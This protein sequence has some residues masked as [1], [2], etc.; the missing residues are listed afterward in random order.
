MSFAC[1]PLLLAALATTVLAGCQKKGEAVA[2]AA[3][4]FRL[5]EAGLLQPIRFAA[6]DIDPAINAC[7]DLGAHVNARWLAANPIPADQTRWGAFGV[8]AERSV[9]VQRQLAEQVAA[10]PAPS[11]IEKIVADFWATGM[12]EA[13]LNADGIKPLASR[14][15]EIEALTDAASVAA[16]LRTVAARGENPVFEFG[17]EA[18]FNDSTMNM[19]YAMQGGTSLP[20]RNYYFDADKKDIRDAYVTHVAKVLELSGVPA[21]DAALQ[22]RDV[23]AMETRLARASKSQ[24]EISRDVSLYYNPVTLVEADKLAPNFPWSSFFA[25]QEIPAPEKFSLAIPDFHRE[26]SRM[27]A[28][29]PVAQWKSYLR[30]HLVDAASPYLSDAFTQQRFE[31]YNKTLRGQAEQRPRWKRVLAVLED[32]AG[33]AMGQLYVQ[34]AFPPESRARM[35]ELVANLSAALKT[36]I[37][38][39]SWMSDATKERALQKWAAFT[40]KIGYPSKWRDWSGLA[41]TRDSY[42][43]NAMAA[44]AFNYR[45]QIGKVGKPVDK[46]EWGMT[47][48]TVNA[49]YHPLLNE[50]VFPAAILQPPFFDPQADDAVNYAGIGGVIGHELTHGY[51][52]QGARF[53]PD[54]KFE[55]WWTPQDEQRFKALTG[56]LVKQ[57]NAYEV[58]PG[59]KVNGNLT[60]GE[61]IA[62]L[63]GLSI[64]WDALQ[65]A[66]E[67][68][69]DPK[70][71]GLSREQR[72]FYSW[73]AIWRSQDRPETLKVQLASDPHAPATT[74][75]NGPVTN[76]PAFAAAFGCKDTDPMVNAGE[77]RVS[78]W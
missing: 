8:L 65:R 6:T 31:F 33:E 16:H 74:R 47:P 49:Y 5:D 35:D 75:V 73:A 37:E 19:G 32:S 69:A 29:V 54:G 72:F 12:D 48:Q 78:I 23:M 41:T 27:I 60:L 26:V 39:L 10:K 58:A 1:R 56:Q 28:D 30:F 44:A 38:N 11:G 22:A 71:D 15:A 53:G 20:D 43:E 59:L 66:S 70:V 7:V 50:I 25:A 36:R 21:T 68:K 57:Y 17:P 51:D 46:T 14:L 4:A 76:H 42:F 18:D 24:E 9:Q 52:D 61:N 3:P 55:Q 13:K 34:V 45:W 62:D 63:G 40:P 64:A 67:G 77:K 2:D